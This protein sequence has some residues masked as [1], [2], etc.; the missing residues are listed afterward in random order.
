MRAGR[1][2]TADDS[3]R[4]ERACVVDEDFARRNWPRGDA[5][6]QKLFFG[7]EEGPESEAFTVVGIVGTVKQADVTEE[8]A[9]GAVYYPFGLRA[10]QRAFIVV[11]TSL[12]PES[13]APTLRRAVRLV[14]ADLP[15]EDVRPMETRLADSLVAR[16]SPALLTA[17]FA[18]TALLL[19]AIGTYGALSYA[20]A[21]RH[22]E[23]SV[24][25]AVGARPEQIRG[26]FLA[27]GL[28]LLALGVGLGWCGA[29]LAGG[30]MRALLFG[31]PALHLPTLAATAGVLTL[32][33]LAACVFPAHRA[34]KIDPALALRSE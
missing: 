20:V 34:T 9:I 17:I 28:R 5:L 4:M 27:F 10:D 26:Q 6:G 22:R 2:L 8:Q 16:R 23:I 18:F 1:F 30:T 31:V 13:F 32:V 29:M 25:L 19:T 21:Q 12:A 15:I 24:R 7:G 3:R 33:A 14:D 11:R